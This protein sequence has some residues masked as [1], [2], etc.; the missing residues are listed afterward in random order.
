MQSVMCSG[1]RRRSSSFLVCG[2]P[3]A[4]NAHVACHARKATAYSLSLRRKTW[5]HSQSFSENAR[6]AT[7]TT[8]NWNKLDRQFVSRHIIVSRGKSTANVLARC[9]CAT[10]GVTVSRVLR[11][12]VLL[13]HPRPV[14]QMGDRL[15]MV[16]NASDIENAEKL[17]GNRAGSLNEPN[18]A[19]ILWASSSDSHWE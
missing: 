8:V 4:D 7:G 13:C 17:I 3:R 2:A 18:L 10:F 5:R 15:S 1:R 6:A 16:G 19:V 9:V 12:S 11:S 14:L